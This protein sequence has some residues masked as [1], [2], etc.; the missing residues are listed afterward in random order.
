MREAGPVSPNRA[1]HF[2]LFALVVATAFGLSL[3]L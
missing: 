1:I 2:G 3:L